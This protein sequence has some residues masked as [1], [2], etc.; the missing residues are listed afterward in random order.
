MTNQNLIIEEILD[1]I[2]LAM[3]EIALALMTAVILCMTAKDIHLLILDNKLEVEQCMIV[4]LQRHHHRRNNFRVQVVGIM[5]EMMR[6]GMKIDQE[7]G[8]VICDSPHSLQYD[9]M[10]GTEFHM[11][12]KVN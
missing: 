7:M 1:P 9:M 6:I 10:K 3:I 2:E 8:L 11:Q 5:D 4:T 12:K